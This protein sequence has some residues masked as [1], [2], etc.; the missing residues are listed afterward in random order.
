MTDYLL[1]ILT[2]NFG[3]TGT[4]R[5]NFGSK[6]YTNLRCF[7]SG[8]MEFG[9]RLI[10]QRGAL[11]PYFNRTQPATTRVRTLLQVIRPCMLHLRPQAV[12]YMHGR[13]GYLV[14]ITAAA[15]SRLRLDFAA[16]VIS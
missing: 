6:L 13:L 7:G 16:A 15:Y 11:T 8:T 5:S 9:T 1:S 14:Y 3:T 10:L 4:P 12:T 2:L